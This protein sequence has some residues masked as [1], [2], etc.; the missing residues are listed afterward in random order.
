MSDSNDG[1]LHP[2][3]RTALPGALL[4]LTGLSAIFFPQLGSL[5]AK[6]TLS[7][8]LIVAGI[9]EVAYG[10]GLAPWTGAHRGW[11][12]GAGALYFSTG[13][14]MVFFPF[15]AFL[16][17]AVWLA[18]FIFLGGLF[19]MGVAL[20]RWGHGGAR[21]MFL[22][23]TAS[24]CLAALIMGG[25]PD[26]VSWVLGVALGAELALHGVALLSLTRLS[27]DAVETPLA[28]ADRPAQH[29]LKAELRQADAL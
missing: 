5:A 4:L 12:M 28:T 8:G 25:L 19:R 21:W 27:L 23:G 20:R 14:L 9:I 3:W 2:P 16:A 29:E 15:S 7:A 10:F 24:L 1:Q 17:I 22:S 6:V 11:S 26:S 13:L 18:T